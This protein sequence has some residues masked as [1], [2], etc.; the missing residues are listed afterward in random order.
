M[1]G[2]HVILDGQQV[3]HDAEDGLFDLAGVTGAG[4][5]DHALLE[6]DDH[7]GTGVEALNRRV[8]LITGGG[9]DAEV[10]LAGARN[11]AGERT[12]EHLLNKERLAGT[13]TGDEQAAR[14][15]AV[16]AG[17]AARDEDIALVEIVDD[18]GL[19]GL[20]ALDGQRAVDGAPGDLVVH[21]GRV[22]DK[23]VIGRTAGALPRLDH[24]RAVRGHAAL[25]APDG[26]LDELGRRQVNQQA[27]LILGGI[28][29]QRK[30]K[31]G[32]YFCRGNTRHGASFKNASRGRALYSRKA[33][34][35]RYAK[36][37]LRQRRSARPTVKNRTQ[38]A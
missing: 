38:A 18:A 22:D 3:V 6:V 31:V 5:Q 36:T 19:N 10:R 14:V 17:H 35:T 8:A 34:C 25:F 2:Q 27:R 1:H 33:R 21:V 37:F 12:S 13:L 16:G 20:V 29:D 26:I 23:A 4:D 15:V 28:L 30:T 7:G 9:Q 24:K 11:F 32:Q